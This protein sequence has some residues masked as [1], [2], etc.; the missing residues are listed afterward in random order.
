LHTIT[1]NKAVMNPLSW[2]P[3]SYR[4]HIDLDDNAPTQKLLSCVTIS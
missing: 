4:V 2:L 3:R 1:S